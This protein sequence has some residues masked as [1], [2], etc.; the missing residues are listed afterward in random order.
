MTSKACRKES[1]KVYAS[2]IWLSSFG[3]HSGLYSNCVQQV[4]VVLSTR[5]NFQRYMLSSISIAS[6][7]EK[8]DKN[9]GGMPDAFDRER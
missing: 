5:V 7:S 8:F 3:I 6:A 9:E 4:Y 2:S 1:F